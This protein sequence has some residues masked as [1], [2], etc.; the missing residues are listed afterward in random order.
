MTKVLKNL[1]ILVNADVDAD[2][3][4]LAGAC[5]S[6]GACDISNAVL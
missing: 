6:S 4:R 1:Y 5:E 3:L 2:W